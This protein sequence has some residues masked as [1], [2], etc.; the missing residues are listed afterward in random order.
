[1]LMISALMFTACEDS[2]SSITTSY[3]TETCTS[4]KG[5]GV[6]NVCD[7]AGQNSY[8]GQA[9]R[10]CTVCGGDGVCSLCGGSGSVS[11]STNSQARDNARKALNEGNQILYGDDYEYNE[12]GSACENCGGYGY[13]DMMCTWCDGSGIDPAWESSKGSATHSFAEKDCASCGGAGLKK[14][15]SCGG[16]GIAD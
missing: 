15:D 3:Q 6:C 11:A 4:C 5:N 10:T 14:C 2:S 8:S 7:G 13:L 12:S 1:M 9:A 16:T